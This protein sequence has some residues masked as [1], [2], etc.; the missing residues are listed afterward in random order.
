MPIVRGSRK[1]AQRAVRKA[2]WARIDRMTGRGIRRQIVENPDAAPDM[3][4]D[5]DVQAIRAKTGMSQAKFA[6]TFGFSV[7][8]LQ[9][10]ERGAK[11][12]SGAARTLLI[13]IDRQPEAVKRA[14]RA[15]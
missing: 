7:R 14:L 6:K 5:F 8:T 2:D 15:A 9:E 11:F 13:V 4:L 1:A 3:A 10:W 12:P